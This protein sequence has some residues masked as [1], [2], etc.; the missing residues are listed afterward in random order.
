MVSVVAFIVLQGC[1]EKNEPDFP[2]E[3]I[4]ESPVFNQND[5]A[6]FCDV[7]KEAYK[8]YENLICKKYNI[9]LDDILS[10]SE[11]C[12]WIW[13]EATKEAR[14]SRLNILAIDTDEYPGCVSSRILELDSLRVLRIQGTGIHGS[15]PA[16]P[17]GKS[18]LV[19]L[20]IWHT[21]MTSIPDEIFQYPDIYDFYLQYNYKMSFPTGIV[22]MGKPKIHLYGE[23]TR[24]WFNDNEFTGIC[25]MNINQFVNLTNNKFTSIDWSGMENKDYK[26][27]L[28]IARAPGP[29][30]ADNP[31]TTSVPDYILSDT[32]AIIYVNNC[33]GFGYSQIAGLPSPEEISN[34]KEEWKRNHPEEA[35][36]MHF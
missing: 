5:S 22:K 3:P 25:P 29:Y 18:R 17:L 13:D 26:E 11:L 21:S 14:I 19:S 2:I 6:V 33:F 30:L 34:M 20:M 35:K 32:L 28:K 31:I 9:R 15:L 16:H 7:F 23:P 24:F 8:G 10:W 36:E 4:S 1:G 12:G 27:A